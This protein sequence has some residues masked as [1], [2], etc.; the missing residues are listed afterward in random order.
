MVQMCPGLTK[1]EG[2]GGTAD[3]RDF[4]SLLRY[5]N[6]QRISFYSLPKASLHNL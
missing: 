4:F 6:K 5:E 1:V 2:E 3:L